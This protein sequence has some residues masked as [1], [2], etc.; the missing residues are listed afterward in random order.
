MTTDLKGAAHAIADV[1]N[2]MLLATVDI[3]APAERVFRAITSDEI[4]NWWGSP[5]TYRTTKW[6]G[7]LRV[8]GAWRTE[9]VSKDGKPFAV[10]GEFLEIDPPQKLVQ[11][12]RA[13]WDGKN[14]TTITWRL[15][16]I[17][18][19]TRLTLRHDG[20]AGRKQAC[21][22]HTQ[23]WAR[24]LDLLR[25]HFKTSRRAMAGATA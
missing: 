24:V 11:T 4:L 2:G 19:G 7:D 13:D 20:F 17:D 18:G 8:G 10:D 15:E 9:G 3:A 23:G 22:G 16:A 1:A 25:D 5:D 12:W 6:I 14:L 21:E